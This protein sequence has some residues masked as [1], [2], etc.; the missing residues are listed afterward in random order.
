MVA[1]ASFATERQL[2]AD[3]STHRPDHGPKD[4][5]L[6]AGMDEVGRGALAGPVTVGISAVSPFTTLLIPGLRDS[7]MLSARRRETLSDTIH[8]SWMVGIGHAEPAE[9]DRWGINAA[10][11]VAGHRAWYD[12]VRRHHRVPDVLI[13]DGK[14]NWLLSLP[15]EV[16]EEQ[17]HLPDELRVHLQVKA[18]RDCA[19]VAAASIVAKV[20]R[21]RLMT[22]ADAFYPD[23]GWSHNK[24]YGSAQHRQA[25]RDRGISPYHRR[26]WHLIPAP[27]RQ[28]TLL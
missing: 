3:E 23:Y 2:A 20:C 7:K 12:L 24:G 9:I 11:A 8:T 22:E 25:L 18:D 15:V 28:D 4:T 16:A 17:R 14:F 19:S 26:S 21:D 27:H 10:L 6:V 13:L 1:D 5:I